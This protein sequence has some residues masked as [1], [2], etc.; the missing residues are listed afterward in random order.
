M[1]GSFNFQ[2]FHSIQSIIGV[3]FIRFRGANLR[4]INSLKCDSEG[5]ALKVLPPNDKIAAY[6]DKICDAV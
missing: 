4:I 1:E 5:K 6:W 2:Q 3:R